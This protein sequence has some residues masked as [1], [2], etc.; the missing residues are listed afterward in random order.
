L[1]LQPAAAQFGVGG[2]RKKGSSFQEL[3]EQAKQVQ[4]GDMPNADDLAQLQQMYGGGAGGAGMDKQMEEAMEMLM[5]MSPEDLE[6]QMQ[7]AMK[8]LTDGDMLKT[9]MEHSD[10]IIKTLEDTEA[11]PPEELAKLKADPAY[12]KEKMTESFGQM[13]DIFNDPEIM[14]AATQTIGTMTQ[15]M[16]NPEMMTDLM[17][18]LQ[19]DFSSDEQIEKARLELLA[20]AE[21]LPPVLKEQFESAE[22]Q[23]LLTDS[24]L[25]RES[26]K[27]GAGMLGGAG[28][29]EL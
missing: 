26:V 16:K 24:K 8:M 1:H 22:M 9:M 4:D 15:F 17:K 23:E 27:E 3:N 19:A 11:V 13:K 5:Q 18:E 20:G 28:V 21:D 6:Q 12:F 10:E 7:D 14:K 2:N 25:W 29:G